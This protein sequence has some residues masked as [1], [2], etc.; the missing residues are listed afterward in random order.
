MNCIMNK[1][2]NFSYVKDDVGY[3]I[4]GINHIINKKIPYKE[5]IEPRLINYLRMHYFYKIKAINP[6][7]PLVIEYWIRQNDI[8]CINNYLRKYN[9]AL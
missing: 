3:K 9:I 6:C 7:I 5:D 2:N 1:I 4:L 8:V